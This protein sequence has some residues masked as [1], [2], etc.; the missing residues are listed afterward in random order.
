MIRCRR[1]FLAFAL[2]ILTGYWDIYITERNCKSI[3]ILSIPSYYAMRD[4]KRRNKKRE[5]AIP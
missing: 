1:R 3:D 4:V 5:L 2:F